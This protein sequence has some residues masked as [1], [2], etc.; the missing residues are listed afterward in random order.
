MH[1]DA[2]AVEADDLDPELEQLKHLQLLE[3]PIE[4][5]RFRPAAHARV[6][7]VPA[8]V[9]GW[10]PAPAAAVHSD[11]Q[12]G[13]EEPEVID[14]DVAALHGQE[15]LDQRELLSGELHTTSHHA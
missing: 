2:G 3:D 11:V 10:Q 1:L 9:L 8:A 14:A 5:A 12:D 6:D 13:V 15:V 4:D 7:R